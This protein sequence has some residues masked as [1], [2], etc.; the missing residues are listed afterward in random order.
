MS[1]PKVSSVTQYENLFSN[2]MNQQLL[3]NRD[4]EVFDM[5]S[6]HKPIIDSGSWLPGNTREIGDPEE[7]IPGISGGGRE[8][9]GPGGAVPG[10][11]GGDR[12]IDGPGGALPGISSGDR[13]I[14]GPGGINP[15]DSNI[16]V[17]IPENKIGTH[18]SAPL[19]VCK[20]QEKGLMT[21]SDL[22]MNNI[23]FAK[24]QIDVLS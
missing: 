19:I 1:I 2:N 23:R 14:D 3:P 17:S 11:S 7:A 15:E 16:P 10:I 24:P 6:V 21:I 18:L 8:I 12:E 5:E 4:Y 13:G 20:P 22:Y 9:D